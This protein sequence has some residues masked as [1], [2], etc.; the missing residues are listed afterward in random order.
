MPVPPTTIDSNGRL[1]G[2]PIV[3]NDSRDS[4][5]DAEEYDERAAKLWSVYVEEAESHDKALVETWKDDMEGIIIFVCLPISSLYPSFGDSLLLG[6]F[7]FSQP[8]CLS[9]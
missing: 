1:P 7:I 8:D 9:R 2:G 6:R 5:H 3:L 4:H